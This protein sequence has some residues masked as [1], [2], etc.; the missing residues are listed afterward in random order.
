MVHLA[1]L[2]GSDPWF[3]MPHLADDA[4]I[5]SFATYVRN[6]LDPA[7]TVRVEYS[8]EWW[9]WNFQQT[10]WLKAQTQ[11]HWGVENYEAVLSYG[12]KMAT[13]MAVIWREV[14]A[15]EPEG[16]LLAVLGSQAA[17]P[18][19]SGQVM[20]AP[21][22]LA[23]EPRAYI[24]PAS[25]FDELAIT[26]YFGNT[27]I[28]NETNRDALLAAI[29]DPEIDAGAMVLDWLQDPTFHSS[30]PFNAAIWAEQQATVNKEGLRLTSYEGGQHLHHFAFI[31]GITPEQENQLTEFMIDFV[32]SDYMAELYADAWNAWAAVSDGPFMQFTDVGYPSK[33]GSWGAY[34]HLSDETPR[35]KILETLNTT[36]K[37]W[38][39]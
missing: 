4:Y 27:V 39:E 9:N 15:Q 25:V 37:P 6:N 30:I 10:Q 2:V 11:A 3:N 22:W 28:G 20:N 19:V 14:F 23:N 8:N 12:A 26:S 21:I 31:A 5:Q 7:L 32:R 36:T 17:N 13:N 18:W 35:T 29:H 34:S 38:W 33:W 1:N 24:Q 16:R